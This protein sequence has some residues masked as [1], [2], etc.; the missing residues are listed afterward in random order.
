MAHPQVTIL[1]CALEYQLIPGDPSRPTLVFLHDGLGSISTWRGFPRALCRSLGAPGLLFSREGYGGS[2]PLRRSRGVHYLHH[3]ALGRLPELLRTLG[4]DQPYLFGHSDGASIALLYG[5]RNPVRGMTLLAPHVFVEPLTLAGVRALQASWWV[6]GTRARLA[7]HHT[8][9]D[10]AF[11]G[12]S[13]AWLD[14]AFAS[15]DIRAELGGLSCPVL[16]MQGSADPFGTMA[17]VLAVQQATPRCNQLLLEGCGHSPHKERPALILEAAL[18]H[19][20]A[21]CGLPGPSSTHAGSGEA[22][23]QRCYPSGA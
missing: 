2:S 22:I 23:L 20:N 13:S 5:A 11:I 18:A 8:D 15:W 10:E 12:W 14:P 19:Y 21:A 17:Q 4:I 3:E 9:V 1:G 6:D 16:A 7:A